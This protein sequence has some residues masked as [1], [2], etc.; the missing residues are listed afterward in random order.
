MKGSVYSG[1][2]L[3]TLLMAVAR[4][5]FAVET[6]DWENLV[7]PV[8]ESLDPYTRLTEDQQESL[9]DL[10]LVR[11]RLVAGDPGADLQQ[12]LWMVREQGAGGDL[13]TDLEDLERDAIANLEATGVDP[14]EVLRELT[15]FL[16]LVEANKSRL[17]EDLDGKEVRIPGY[18]LPTEYSGDEVVE[19]LLV[20][21]VG[22][23]IHVPPPPLNQMVHVEL[24]DGYANKRLFAPV[25]VTGRILSTTST[26]SISMNDGA[27]DVEAGYTIQATDVAP[28]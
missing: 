11:E 14:A 22:A 20:P 12:L 19:F 17:V 3:F 21:Y 28:Y 4:P 9:F 7:P 26:Q 15:E 27:M 6:I 13:D 18:V 2:L 25:W 1:I 5:A 24:D 10:W 16:T 23:C 8:D